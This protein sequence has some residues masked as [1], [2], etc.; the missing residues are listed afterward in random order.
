MRF[1]NI[2][3]H[4]DGSLEHADHEGGWVAIRR[5]RNGSEE[6]TCSSDRDEISF[7][8]REL[9]ASDTRAKL[10]V[11][12]S[13]EWVSATYQATVEASNQPGY[14]LQLRFGDDT[15]FTFPPPGN[16]DSV[17]KAAS[18]T[19]PSFWSRASSHPM[20]VAI[21]SSLLTFGLALLFL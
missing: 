3:Q 5:H 12:V 19:A 7:V 13:V 18:P 14:P 11:K 4:F 20:V 21:V 8:L 16:G 9:K 1:G 10:A 17:E 2:V 15:I 6:F